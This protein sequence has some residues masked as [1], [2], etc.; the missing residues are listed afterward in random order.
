MY[1]IKYLVATVPIKN[2]DL[3]KVRELEKDGYKII[4]YQNPSAGKLFNFYYDYQSVSYIKDYVETLQKIDTLKT[5][6]LEENLDK[7]LEPGENEITLHKNT[8]TYY[9]LTVSTN[10]EGI[11]TLGDSYSE[12]WKAKIDGKS[13]KIYPANIN[14]KA[15]LVPEGTHRVEIFYHPISIIAGLIITLSAYLLSAFILF[16]KTKAH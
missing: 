15:L 6:I 8:S 12:D 10:S 4:L 13:V 5:V 11:L 16:K 1:S 9:D 2:S 7:K 3:E 14:S